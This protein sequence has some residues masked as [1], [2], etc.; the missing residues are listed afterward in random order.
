MRE[1]R[2]NELDKKQPV[3]KRNSG[4]GKIIIFLII[5]AIVIGGGIYLWQGRGES[6]EHDYQAVFLTNGQVYFGKVVKKTK[7]EVHLADIYYLQVNQPLQ[8]ASEE[9]KDEEEEEQQQP[10]LSLIKLGDELHGPKD[11]MEINRDQVLF[12]E[13]LKEDSQ[14]VDAIKNYSS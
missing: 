5:I 6:S 11:K 1:K 3:P 14:V 8:P 13:D 7:T 12:I 4:I 2:M 10:E 9:G